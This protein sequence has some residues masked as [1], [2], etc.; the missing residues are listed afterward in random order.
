MKREFFKY[1]VFAM[2]VM[3]SLSACEKETTNSASVIG[4]ATITGT[5]KGRLNTTGGADSL[6]NVPSTVKLYAKYSS[7]DLVSNPSATLP[8]AYIIKEV[9]VTGDTYS[10]TVDANLKDVKVTLYGDDFRTTLTDGSN[11]PLKIFTL[12]SVSVKVTK[13]VYRIKDLVYRAK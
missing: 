7:K 1:A 8:Y 9:V 10:F 5:V 13:D 11:N 12:D 3:F 4:K 2:I 6:S